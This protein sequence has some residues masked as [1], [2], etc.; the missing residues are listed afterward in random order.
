MANIN[1]F[2]PVSPDTFLKA[3]SDMA[4]AKFGHLNT[5]VDAY[6]TLDTIVS[7]GTIG[8]VGTVTQ[9]S[10]I[11]DAVTLNASKGVITTAATTI[12]AGTSATAFTL[13]NSFIKTDSVILTNCL[14][15]VTGSSVTALVSSIA[16]GS[17]N[18]T[19]TNGGNASTGSAIIKIHFAI[20]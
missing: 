11:T 3:G 12:T 6:N 8:T 13:T 19:L 9:A 10:V 14:Q 5:I 16:N 18:I 20:L 2:S 15:G 7:N 1:K 17:C 4:L